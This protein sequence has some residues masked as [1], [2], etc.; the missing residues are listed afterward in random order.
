MMPIGSER[1]R[2]EALLGWRPLVIRPVR[3]ASLDAERIYDAVERDGRVFALRVG[4]SVFVHPDEYA[5]LCWAPSDAALKRIGC[6]G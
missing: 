2:R 6:T 4:Q 5:V 1:L 3:H